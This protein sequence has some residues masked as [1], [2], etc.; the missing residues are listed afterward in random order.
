[1]LTFSLNILHLYLNRVVKK[2]DFS[3][4]KIKLEHISK[5]RYGIDININNLL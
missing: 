1:M 5:T 4:K 2:I 3:L